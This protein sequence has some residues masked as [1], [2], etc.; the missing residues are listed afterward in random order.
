LTNAASAGGGGFQGIDPQS[1]TTLMST[2]KSGAGN[3]QPV[4]GSYLGQ[5]SRLGLDTGPINKLL[6]DYG[7]AQGQLAMLQRR[8]DLASHQPSGQWVDGMATSGAGQLQYTTAGQAQTAGAS[9]ARQFTNGKISS[10]DFLAMLRTH[11]D[12][13]DW[14]TGAMRALGQQGLWDIKEDGVP[15]GPEGQADLQALALAVATAMGN[16]V[17]F[18][19][20]DADDPGSEDVTLLAPLLQYA[21]FPPQVLATLGREAMA[22]GYSMYAPEV[23]SALAASPQGAALF[24]HQNMPQIMAYIRAGDHGG[25]LP[26]DQNSAFAA[27]ITAGTAGIHG[28]DPKL[29]AA[30]VNALVTAFNATGSGP[31]PAPLEAAFGQVI[32][33]YWPDVTYAVTSQQQGTPAPDGMTLSAQD[34]APFADEAMHDPATA[35]M[36][37][38][39]AQRQRDYWMNQANAGSSAADYGYEYQAGLVTGFF[40]LQASQAYKSLGS[41][42]SW[43]DVVSSYA[44][45][46]ADL[47]FDV[48]IDPGSA[49]KT[50][51]T[52]VSKDILDSAVSAFTSS[53]S[54]ASPPAAPDYN[55]F[56]SANVRNATA[57]YNYAT[58]QKTANNPGLA[59]LV[60]SA[61]NYGGGSFTAKI[62]NPGSMTPAQKQ[63]YNEWLSSPAVVGYLYAASDSGQ[64]NGLALAYN[65]GYNSYIVNSNL[66]QGG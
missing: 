58:P 23:W 52:D 35:A 37:L 3:A 50:A 62:N 13:P 48:A 38:G 25:G 57:A 43:T 6:Q 36:L 20:P 34:W 45:D 26:S 8:Y 33:S 19:D 4:A 60:A 17:T 41:P 53:L 10:A 16:G 24:L 31:V 42:K 11:E 18:P 30:N 39:L 65:D 21:Q 54:Q 5:F 29:G 63:A 56:Q 27:V 51:A 14:Q 40:D 15:P 66:A 64:N 2:L 28:A 55:G 12:D 61:Q 59:A 47:A 32:R 7:W 1:L 9:A 49:A 22:P 46:A 44:G